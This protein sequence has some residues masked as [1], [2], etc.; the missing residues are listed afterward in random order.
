MDAVAPEVGGEPVIQHTFLH[1]QA[2]IMV[3]LMAENT[4]FF[5]PAIDVFDNR[6]WTNPLNWKC[7]YVTI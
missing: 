6:V 1:V 2:T 7:K 4:E 3:E 5:M